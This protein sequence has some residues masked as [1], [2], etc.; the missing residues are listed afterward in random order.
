M[1]RLAH[2]SRKLFVLMTLLASSVCAGK[3][4]ADDYY[5]QEVYC[6][7]PA[8]GK[9]AFRG[10]LLYWRPY[11]TGIEL[12]FGTG[13][14]AQTTVGDGQVILSDE[15]DIDP[16]FDWDAGY[17]IAVGYEMA[18]HWGIGADWTHFKGN[19]HYSSFDNGDLTSRG[20]LNVTLNQI[21]LILGYDYAVNC[22][23]NV[24]P[25]LGVR[26]TR[27]KDGVKGLI[28]TQLTI[29][30]VPALGEL[31]Y[32][33]HR[34]DYRG[35]GPVLGFQGDYNIG[36]G[37]GLYGTA[38]A[39]ILYGRFRV[40]MDDETLLGTRVLTQINTANARHLHSFDPNV[41]LALGLFWKTDLLECAQLNMKLGFEHHEYF[42]QNH[43]SV[44]RGDMSFTGGIFSIDIVL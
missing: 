31:R 1:Q 35:V 5:S 27:I 28:T 13:S 34:Q 33:N 38:A 10:D 4:V 39:S 40:N 30:D 17:R 42:N 16:H 18:S 11:L 14:I 3:A 19:G 22:D 26:G 43:F 15:F 9:F 23:F 12:C 36:C 8:E 44:F 20:K 21:D 24:K 25:F 41:D 29:D 2:E 7:E 37:V 6:C 32:F